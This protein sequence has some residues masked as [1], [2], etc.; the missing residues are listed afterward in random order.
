MSV[1]LGALVSL[2]AAFLR[3]RRRRRRE[4]AQNETGPPSAPTRLERIKEKAGRP[5]NYTAIAALVIGCISQAFGLDIAPA[6]V[7]VLVTAGAT[8]FAIWSRQ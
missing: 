6:E 1:D 2:G 7:D 3:R 4:Q 8:L 5:L